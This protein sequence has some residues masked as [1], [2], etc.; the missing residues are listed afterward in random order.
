MFLTLQVPVPGS[1]G[2]RRNLLVM[3]VCGHVAF[4]SGYERGRD[5]VDELAQRSG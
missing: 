5:E 4:I 1:A 2:I 3:P